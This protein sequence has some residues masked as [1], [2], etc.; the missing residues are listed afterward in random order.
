[1]FGVHQSSLGLVWGRDGE[2]DFGEGSKV[3]SMTLKRALQQL[4]HPD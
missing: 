4:T 1:M 3:D 2:I